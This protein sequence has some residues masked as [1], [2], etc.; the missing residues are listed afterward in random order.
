MD[1]VE[2]QLEDVGGDTAPYVD[3]TGGTYA[4]GFGLGWE[5]PV[6]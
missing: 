4:L 1:A 3:S 6:G 5:G 2:A